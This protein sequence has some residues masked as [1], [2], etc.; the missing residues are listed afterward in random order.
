M[1]SKN[2]LGVVIGEAMAD[3][4]SMILHVLNYHD[5]QLIF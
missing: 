3:Y 4:Y 2:K 1:K 5:N